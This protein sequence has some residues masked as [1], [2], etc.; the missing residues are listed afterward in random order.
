VHRHGRKFTPNELMERATGKPLTPAPW[1][2]YVHRK[3]EDLYRLPE[4]AS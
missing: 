2:A 4:A 1:I 3:F